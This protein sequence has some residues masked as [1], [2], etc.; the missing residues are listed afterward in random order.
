MSAER[1]VGIDVSKDHLDVHVRPDRTARRFANT[2]DG[3]EQLVAVL[4]PLA[5]ALVVLEATGGYQRA[6]AGALADAALPVRVVNP[7][8]ARAFATAVGRLAKTDAVDAAVLAEYAERVGPAARPLAGA[9]AQELQALLA[10]RRQ[11]VGMRT[12]ERNRLHQATAAAVRASLAAVLAVLDAQIDGLDGELVAAIAAD[13]EWAAK[14]EAMRAV[15]GVG[16]VVS[17][18]L[19]ASLPELGG[20]TRQQAAALAGL[21]PV[22]RDSGR[23]VGR[24][25][26]R[27]GR[28]EVR[29]A[30][31]LAAHSARRFHPTL[32]GFADR[33][34]AAGKAPKVILVA[35]A[36]KLVVMLNAILRDLNA[37]RKQPGIA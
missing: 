16:P 36:R 18:T 27:G 35:V 19:L 29:T 31:F 24:R 8:R 21:A 14:E 4:G 25:S 12:M 20:V 34:A 33:L 37:G 1:F 32:K 15:C 11:V 7:A 28:A 26:V 30:L 10:R 17:R 23:S 2:A 3:H 22:N 9:A 5:P 13:P 6:V